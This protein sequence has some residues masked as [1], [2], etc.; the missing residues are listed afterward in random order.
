MLLDQLDS[1][2]AMV[3]DIDKLLLNPR[4]GMNMDNQ[5]T[6]PNCKRTYSNLP[7]IEDAARGE[8]SDTQSLICECGEKISYWRIT[9]QLRDQKKFGRLLKNKFLGLLKSRSKVNIAEKD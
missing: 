1:T 3:T 9:E 2:P 7:I 5:I 6:C 8:G 4:N